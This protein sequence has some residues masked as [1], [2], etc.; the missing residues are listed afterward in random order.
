MAIGPDRMLYLKKTLLKAVDDYYGDRVPDITTFKNR[1]RKT[2]M[3]LLE[4]EVNALG[5]R[6]RISQAISV[7]G[8]KQ[9]V[10]TRLNNEQSAKL[11]ELDATHNEEIARLK[12]KHQTENKKLV[13]HYE[14]ALLEAREELSVA[15]K[16]VSRIKRESYFAG[17]KAED[18]LRSFYGERTIDNAITERVDTFIEQNLEDDDDGKAVQQRLHEETIIGDLVHL[19]E[20]VPELREQLLVFIQKGKLPEITVEA[21]LIENGQDL[22]EH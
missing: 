20:K 18:D 2:F 1:K 19:V 11:A 17:L 16:E 3:E 10:V 13:A 5:W 9:G 12:L 7:R 14:P 8:T 4:K 6:E 15:E 21:W 22:N